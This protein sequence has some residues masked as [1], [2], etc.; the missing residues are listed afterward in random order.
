MKLS[1]D[2]SVNCLLGFFYSKP[3]ECCLNLHIYKNSYQEL[4]N[5]YYDEDSHAVVQFMFCVWWF[6][7]MNKY[8]GGSLFKTT[9]MHLI[10]TITEIRAFQW[11]QME[12]TV[13]GEM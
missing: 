10:K 12:G 5:S 3:I 8:T 2:F 9:M 13:T 11:S 1:Y 6:K 7:Y 4:L